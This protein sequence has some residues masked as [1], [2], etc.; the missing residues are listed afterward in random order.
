[1]CTLLHTPRCAGRCALSLGIKDHIN[2]ERDVARFMVWASAPLQRGVTYSACPAGRVRLGRQPTPAQAR[3]HLT[4][5]TVHQ[6][7]NACVVCMG[8]GRS[9]GWIPQGNLPC[10]LP[11]RIQWIP[12]RLQPQSIGPPAPRRGHLRQSGCLESLH[13]ILAIGLA[14]HQPTVTHGR[15]AVAH[16]A[17]P[18]HCFSWPGPGELESWH[19]HWQARPRRLVHESS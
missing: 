2:K 14:K 9:N 10:A 11:A 5:R 16:G 6:V 18:P 15:T 1:M 3:A 7:H 12:P 8:G 4:T 13:F 17:R 19:W